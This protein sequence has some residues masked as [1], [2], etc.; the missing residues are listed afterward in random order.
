MG[1]HKL[2]AQSNDGLLL[3]GSIGE[4]IVNHYSFYTAFMTQEE[5]RLV[6]GNRTLGTLPI[7][8]PVSEGSLII[9]GGRRWS[10][11]SVDSQKKVIELVPAGGGKAPVFGGQAGTIHDRIRQEM[12]AVY[13][14][15]QLPIFLDKQ[16]IELLGEARSNFKRLELASNAIIRHG[17]NSLIFCWMGDVAMDT[18]TVLLHGHKQKASNDGIAVTAL[19]VTPADLEEKI[20]SI[21]GSG[22][23]DGTELARIVSNK[24]REK[25]DQYLS[26]SLLCQDYASSHLD[27][28]A[29]FQSLGKVVENNRNSASV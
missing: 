18:I 11:I 14:E 5:Y 4:K 22:I 23:V 3:H 12:F 10:V 8:R 28:P 16:A 15:E 25:Y 21:L 26:E 13:T 17:K 7:D 27:I 2:I 9:F 29:A 1:E 20:R 6:S 19:D 24:A